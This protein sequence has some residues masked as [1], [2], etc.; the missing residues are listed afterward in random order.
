MFNICGY[1]EGDARNTIEKFIDSPN[2]S[3]NF[4]KHSRSIVGQV[5]KSVYDRSEKDKKRVFVNCWHLN[6]YESAAMWDLYLKNEEG[7]AIQ[8]TFNR[9]KK[10]LGTN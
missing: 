2:T 3:E 5:V 7:V 8:T 6:E 9:I 1:G 10:S 4:K